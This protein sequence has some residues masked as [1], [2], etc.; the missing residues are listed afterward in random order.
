METTAI[1][2]Q[3]N[4]YFV[5]HQCAHIDNRLN[6]KLMLVKCNRSWIPTLVGNSK[7][8]KPRCEVCEMLDTRKKHK[9]REQALPFHQETTIV[10]LATLSIYSCVTLEITSERHQTGY[11][12]H[13]VIIKRASETTAGVS[14]WLFISTNPTIRLKI[15]NVLFWEATSRRRQTDSLVNKR[16]YINS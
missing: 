1:Y 7:C 11:D 3:R 8:M 14:R 2:T 15:C 5:I 4:I 6:L 9:F 16:S 13:L 12:L 10:I